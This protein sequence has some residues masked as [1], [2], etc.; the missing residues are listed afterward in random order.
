MDKSIKLEPEEGRNISISISGTNVLIEILH[1]ED[2]TVLEEIRLS[3]KEID[4]LCDE[5]E[6]AKGRVHPF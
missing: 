3:A 2:N 6:I 4:V 5:L 1:K